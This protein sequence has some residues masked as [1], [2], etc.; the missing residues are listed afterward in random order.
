MVVDLKIHNLKLL[1][2]EKECTFLSKFNDLQIGR[3]VS[4]AFGNDGGRM[5]LDSNTALVPEVTG[6]RQ[7]PSDERESPSANGSTYSR[8][9]DICQ[10][11]P[12][13]RREQI[14]SLEAQHGQRTGR[15]ETPFEW[16][17]SVWFRGS[18][19]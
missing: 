3:F 17:F 7:S 18:R 1:N 15:V 14:R 8:R 4:V 11:C 5:N 10:R 6:K 19:P 16:V 13:P 12:V 9:R 2:F